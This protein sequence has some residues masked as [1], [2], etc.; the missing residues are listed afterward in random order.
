MDQELDALT[1]QLHEW[2]ESALSLDE[3]HFPRELLNELE[4]I[5]S[6]LK[7][8]ID[9]NPAEFDRKSFTEEFVN[10]EMAEVVERFP[11]VRRVLER[12]LGS[13]FMEQLAEEAEGF[14]G[15]DDDDD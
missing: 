6:E 4:D 12:G 8:I 2:T 11:K 15:L 9:E 13:E 1:A 7:T 3:A 10:P 14:G 5:I